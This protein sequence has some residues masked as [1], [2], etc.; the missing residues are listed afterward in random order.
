[1]SKEHGEHVIKHSADISASFSAFMYETSEWK[2]PN[3]WK[4]IVFYSSGEK[5]ITRKTL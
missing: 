4:K 3:F 2:E 1:M 5:T